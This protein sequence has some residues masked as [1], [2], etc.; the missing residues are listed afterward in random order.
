M[1]IKISKLKILMIAKNQKILG[2]FKHLNP[3][4]FGD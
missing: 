3:R 1:K 2:V 4:K